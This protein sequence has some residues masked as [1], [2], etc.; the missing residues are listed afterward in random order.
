MTGT[1]EQSPQPQPRSANVTAEDHSTEMLLNLLNNGSGGIPGSSPRTG[2]SSLP[3]PMATSPHRSYQSPAFGGIGLGPTPQT[4][5]PSG[6]SIWGPVSATAL[7][8]PSE[9]TRNIWNSASD[10]SAG[11]GAFGAA[12]LRRDS[13]AFPAQGLSR[14]FG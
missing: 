9:A 14:G 5:S 13:N 7:P 11:A 6:P 4:G 2:G 3:V 8:A 12:P 10:G 1:R